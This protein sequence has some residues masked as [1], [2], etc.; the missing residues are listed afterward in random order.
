[1]NRFSGK[2]G[3]ARQASR[4]VTT[5]DSRVPLDGFTEAAYFCTQ[6]GGAR[7]TNCPGDCYPSSGLGNTEFRLQLPRANTSMSF[8]GKVL[9][10]FARGRRCPSV[11]PETCRKSQGSFEARA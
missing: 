2:V 7:A 10:M 8:P 4:F 5:E 11:R 1:M 9:S 6:S 3:I